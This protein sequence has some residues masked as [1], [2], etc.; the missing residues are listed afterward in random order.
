M[1]RYVTPET[2]YK[3]TQISLKAL[4]AYGLI[5]EYGGYAS[6]D[7][8]PADFEE[9]LDLEVLEELRKAG[10]IEPSGDPVEEYVWEDTT[11]P[12]PPEWWEDTYRAYGIE[13]R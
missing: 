12:R 13:A 6:L 7:D 3:L 5:A 4:V 1:E 8:F 9:Y 10:L 2:G 11:R